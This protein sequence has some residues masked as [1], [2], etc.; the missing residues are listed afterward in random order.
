MI[1]CLQRGGDGNAGFLYP[2][3]ARRRR[4]RFSDAQWA[5][6]GPL[7]PTDTRGMAR[8]KD[9]RRVLSGI[10]HALRNGGRWADCPREVYWTEE[11]ALQPLCTLGG[12][13]HLGTD[14]QRAGG[15]R[16]RPR[17]ASMRSSRSGFNVVRFVAPR[18]SDF[19]SAHR[20]HRRYSCG[21]QGDRAEKGPRSRP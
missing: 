1:H 7:L 10:V 21:D 15:R 14:I 19:Q 16:R 2:Q 11:D 5:R 8:V 3:A 4:P 13:R 9:D 6:I 12:A 20:F 17:P 18:A